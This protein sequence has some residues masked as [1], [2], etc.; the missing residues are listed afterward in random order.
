MTPHA[1]AG[2]EV[3]GLRWRFEIRLSD[4]S[5]RLGD[6]DDLKIGDCGTIR[7]AYVERIRRFLTSSRCK[8]TEDEKLLLEAKVDDLEMCDD[9]LD[10]VRYALTELYDVFDFQRICAV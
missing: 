4:L 9:D 2:I 5:D 1:L 6:E 7:D 8:L 10:E 3:N